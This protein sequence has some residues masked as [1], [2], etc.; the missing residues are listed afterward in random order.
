MRK[1]QAGAT[2]WSI[3]VRC[4]SLAR[5]LGVSAMPT[6]PTSRWLSARKITVLPDD[7]SSCF[8]D[9]TSGGMSTWC[10]VSHVCVPTSTRSGPTIHERPMPGTA[11]NSDG[12]ASAVSGQLRCWCVTIALPIGCSLAD[13]ALANKRKNSRSSNG[14]TTPVLVD[15]QLDGCTTR[16]FNG[17]GRHTESV[18]LS[19]PASTSATSVSSPSLSR[20]L[21]LAVP[22]VRVPVLSNTTA[23]ILYACSSVLPPLIRMPFIAPRP[24]PTITAVGVAKPSAHGHATTT[25]EMLNSSEN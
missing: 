2:S 22:C 25:T 4:G 17:T 14:A 12:V 9:C 1:I 3:A 21:A 7:S 20:D 16:V 8:S 24:V 6:R 18:T 23:V 13:S 19:L 10:C 15:A 11:S 5:T